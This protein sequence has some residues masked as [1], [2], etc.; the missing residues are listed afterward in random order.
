LELGDGAKAATDSR[1]D[2]DG[3]DPA[4]G[5][6][7]VALVGVGDTTEARVISGGIQQ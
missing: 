4:V 2:G 3:M 5:D 7:V 6:L 1:T